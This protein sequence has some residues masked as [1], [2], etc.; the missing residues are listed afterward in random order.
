MDEAR[1]CDFNVLFAD[2]LC[3]RG[4]IAVEVVHLDLIDVDVDAAERVDCLRESQETDR[5]EVR[6][7][8][9]QVRVQHHDR[10]LGAA[11]GVRRVALAVA[12][13]SEIDVGVAVDRDDLHVA[14]VLVDGGDHDRVA[15]RVLPDL[16]FC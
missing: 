6:D 10:L 9:V 3:H 5:H 13:V 15:S 8:Q 4:L 2:L 7:V 1:L 14:R 11:R 16:A 12:V